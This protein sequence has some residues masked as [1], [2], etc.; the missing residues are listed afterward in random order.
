MDATTAYLADFAL[1]CEF[2]SLPP[3]VV[4]EGKRRLIDT[5][6][7]AIGA[8]DEPLCRTARAFAARYCGTP[9]ATVWGCATPTSAEAAAFA[10]GVMLRYSDSNDTYVVRSNGHPSDVIAAILASGEAVHA[11]GA[12]VLN[13]IAIAYD[14][15]C[16]FVEAID[17]NSRGWDQPVYAVL[18]S[19]LGAGRLMG[20]TREQMGNAVALALTPNM[21]LEQTRRGELSSWKGCAA[22]NAARNA[23]FAALLAREGFTGPAAVFEGRSGLWDVVGRFEW[24][25]PAIGSADHRIG[26]T[27]VKLLPVCYHGQSAAWAALDLHSRVPVSEVRAIEVETYRQAAE[28]MA[29]DAHRWA[30]AT[31]E[32]ADH[33]LPYVIAVALADGAIGPQSFAPARL[34]DPRLV[35]LMRKVTV[36][37]RA[38]FSAE[39][40]ASTPCRVTA[41]LDSGETCAAEVRFPRGHSRNPVDDAELEEKFR[42]LFRGYGDEAQCDAA[43]RAL[44]EVDRADDIGQ[45]LQLLIRTRDSRS[46]VRELAV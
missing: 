44:W 10:N 36:S 24:D 28:F 34:S 4:H 33:S 43:L 17:V 40:P 25:L 41:V 7:C 20:L 1:A 8:Y 2:G 26:R 18:A 22:A 29:G 46:G 30:P 35:E 23:V 13:A 39:Y 12:S 19:A 6:G 27:H 38:D 9:A 5:V 37:E 15:Y 31:R 3:E 14:V 32:T 11:D 42:T 21:A 45:V 16:N